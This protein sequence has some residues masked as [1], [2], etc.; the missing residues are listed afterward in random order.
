[1]TERD[2]QRKLMKDIGKRLNGSVVLKTD[3]RQRQGF[4]DLLILY[5]DKW[6]VLECKK[7]DLSHKQPNQEFY[8]NELGK[9]SFAKFVNPNNKEEVL[10]E[11][12]RALGS[13]G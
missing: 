12:V 7:D 3:A 4:P 2:F 9:M 11:L 8:I 13:E 1:M 5:K 6:A 10:D